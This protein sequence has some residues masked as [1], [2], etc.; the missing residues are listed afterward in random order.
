M[1]E[2]TGA[3]P[4]SANRFEAP[5]ECLP[6]SAAHPPWG[7]RHADQAAER[8]R[9]LQSA[10]TAHRR[11]AGESQPARVPSWTPRYRGIVSASKGLLSSPPTLST[12][13]GLASKGKFCNW[14]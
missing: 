3:G 8:E 14:F 2:S 9:D 10:P 13:F 12:H 4:S 11:V 1:T 6:D 7:D 5:R